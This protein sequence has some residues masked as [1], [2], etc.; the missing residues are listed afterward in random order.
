MVHLGSVRCLGVPENG[1]KIICGFSSGVVSV[2]D[3]RAGIM[4][5]SWKAH[6]GEVIQVKPYGR[7]K[8]VTS[9]FDQTMSL[10]NADDGKLNHHFKGWINFSHE[11]LL[12]LF[13]AY[14]SL[15]T[16]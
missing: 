10:W 3:S 15:C 5:A 13:K 9:S 11:L 14:R 7:R 6:E 4:Q 16:V 12:V 2:L 1:S 8:F